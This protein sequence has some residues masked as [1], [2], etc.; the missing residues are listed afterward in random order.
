MQEL[1]ANNPSIEVVKI[2]DIVHGQF[3]DVFVGVDAVIHTV[4]PLPGQADPE[5]MMEVQSVFETSHPFKA[6]QLI[7]YW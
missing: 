2:T 5:A 4:S 7:F 6:H 3:Q 1:Y